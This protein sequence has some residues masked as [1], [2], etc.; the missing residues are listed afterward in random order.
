MAHFAE[1]DSSNI[2]LRVIV[3]HNNELLD[4]NGIESEAKGIAFCKSHYGEDTNWVQGS[5]N[6]NFRNYFP[7]I[8]Y[9]Y[10]SENDTFIPPQP[11]PSW[12]LDSN[13]RW[14]PPVPKPNEGNWRWNEETLSWI[15]RDEIPAEE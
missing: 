7:G 2:V 10:D 13:F 5:Y 11:Y 6:W 4:E 9:S 14:I 12:T 8:G 1:I 15:P 3:V